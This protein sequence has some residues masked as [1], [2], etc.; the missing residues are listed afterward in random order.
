MEL[1]IVGPW[2]CGLWTSIRSKNRRPGARSAPYEIFA[3]PNCRTA[4]CTV[5]VNVLLV[6]RVAVPGPHAVVPV[7]RGDVHARLIPSVS[8]GCLLVVSATV[9][10][11][12]ARLNRAPSMEN[13]LF[14]LRLAP[15][16]DT[17]RSANGSQ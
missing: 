1:F 9:A 12:C 17:A 4:V 14:P 6:P 13:T 2:N 7:P 8:A 11:H 3:S 16:S 5:L 10:T 15:P